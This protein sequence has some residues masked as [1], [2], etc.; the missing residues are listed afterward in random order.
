MTLPTPTAS[1]SMN[2]VNVELGRTGTTQISFN[3]TNVRV[4]ADRQGSGT[5]ITLASNFYGKKWG[6]QPSNLT[7][8]QG[9]TFFAESLGDSAS[10]TLRFNANGTWEVFGSGQLVDTGGGIWY[11]PITTNIGANYYVKFTKTAGSGGSAT[12]GWLLLNTARSVGVFIASGAF[13]PTY[14][15]QLATDAAGTNI[16][17]TTTSITL[18]VSAEPGN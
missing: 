12:T 10:Q 1:I 11:K 6:V 16:V 17:Q 14:T 7:S 2:Q 9:V 18:Y 5:A 15:V 3:E 4:L 8:L 13:N